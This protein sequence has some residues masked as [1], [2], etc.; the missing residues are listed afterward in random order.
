MA[1]AR[2]ASLRQRVL[3]V[4]ASAKNPG[5]LE[6]RGAKGVSALPFRRSAV[7]THSIA[8]PKAHTPQNTRGG[9]SVSPNNRRD[10]NGKRCRP[11]RARSPRNRWRRAITLSQRTHT[12]KYAT[13]TP[14]SAKRTNRC[15]PPPTTPHRLHAQVPASVTGADALARHVAAS[16]R[17]KDAAVRLHWK[18]RPLGRDPGLVRVFASDEP[19]VIVSVCRLLIFMRASAEHLARGEPSTWL[20]LGLG[21]GLG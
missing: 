6:K 8:R 2:L 21:V 9:K 5:S 19:P 18:G 16:Y 15:Q 20:G 17:L 4:R 11:R 3:Q 12:P 10:Q 7:P 14:H 1:A 13:Y